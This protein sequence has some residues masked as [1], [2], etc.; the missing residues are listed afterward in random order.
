MKTRL[1]KH[2][3]SESFGIKLIPSVEVSIISD[4]NTFCY[5]LSCYKSFLYMTF[6]TVSP[7]YSKKQSF[8]SNSSSSSRTSSSLEHGFALYCFFN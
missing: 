1:L 7:G 2:W 8:S 6:R 5:K 3:T 4:L